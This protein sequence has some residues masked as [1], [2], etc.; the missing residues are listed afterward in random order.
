[1]PI[2]WRWPAGVAKSSHKSAIEVALPESIADGDFFDRP[3]RNCLINTSRRTRGIGTQ[4]QAILVMDNCQHILHGTG[5]IVSQS[6]ESV[7]GLT[8]SWISLLQDM[9]ADTERLLDECVGLRLP[10]RVLRADWR[11]TPE[12][13]F[14]FPAPA[15]F[16]WGVELMLI[17]RDV[18]AVSVLRRAQDNFATRRDF[19]SAA[20]SELFEALASGFYGTPGEALDIT[21]R[22]HAN[23]S[24]SGASWAQSWPELAWT[25]AL[26]TNGD[27]RQ[28]LDA[29]HS[30]LMKQIAMA[31]RWGPVW[32]IHIR[33]WVLARIVESGL[34]DQGR[35]DDV[36]AW[37]VEVARLIGRAT[38]LRQRPGVTITN[39]GPFATDSDQAA[40]ADRKVLGDKSFDVA[41]KERRMLRPEFGEVAGLATGTL[42]VG[43]LPVDHLVLQHAPSTG[44]TLS[45][46][47]KEVAHLVAAG[48][49][50]SS[51]TVRRGRSFRTFDA[52]AASIFQRLSIN[53]R[54]D[55]AA[56][57]PTSLQSR[58]VQEPD[59]RPES[60]HSRTRR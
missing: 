8:M 39:L 36:S 51:I 37:A 2:F 6:L 53:R 32:A 12:S 30:A 10:N 58:L 9:P 59:T 5:R 60:L 43:K 46:A 17:H 3:T 28:A 26:T 41:E 47:E 52:Q 23:A 27:T 29:V 54:S 7:S 4:L 35:I 20:M 33:T 24:R 34:V 15:E 50:N 11:K 21:E 42:S 48:W 45:S 14:R 1:M 49:T 57:V 38:T 40:A 16:A 13:D 25:I 56:L 31:D 18:R 55:I 44:D 19:S 22:H